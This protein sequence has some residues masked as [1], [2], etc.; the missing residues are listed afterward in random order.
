MKLLFLFVVTSTAGFFSW[1]PPIW[2]E[3]C[4][5]TRQDATQCLK[6]YMDRNQDGVITQEEMMKSLNENITPVLRPFLKLVNLD[7]ILRDCDYNED[8][9]FTP[10]D[11]LMSNET[12]CKAKKNLCTI[13]WFCRRAEQNAKKHID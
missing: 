12:C 13:E 10:Q 4:E 3:S 6:R 8:G 11:F 1:A 9:V 7:N 5:F 2:D